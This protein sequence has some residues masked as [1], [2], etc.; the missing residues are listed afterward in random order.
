MGKPTARPSGRR[1]SQVATSI[2]TSTPGFSTAGRGLDTL[3][4]A[5]LVVAANHYL[6]TWGSRHTPV[7]APGEGLLGHH[8]GSDEGDTHAEDSGGV[9]GTAPQHSTKKLRAEQAGHQSARERRERDD[10]EELR[11]GHCYYPFRLSSSST[12]TAGTNGS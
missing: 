4:R 9:R 12:A 6:E 7:G 11:K 2:V 10:Q 5:T 3:A 1:T 8:A